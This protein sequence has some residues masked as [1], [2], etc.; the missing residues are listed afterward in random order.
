MFPWLPFMAGR[1]IW[2]CDVTKIN[3]QGIKADCMDPFLCDDVIEKRA[4]Q[5]EF[6]LSDKKIKVETKL[7]RQLKIIDCL[8]SPRLMAQVLNGTDA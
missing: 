1:S 5:K 4:L 7:P 2:G 3:K 6:S 8:G